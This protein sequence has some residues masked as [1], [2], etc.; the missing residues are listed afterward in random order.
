[1]A[2]KQ[3]IKAAF[4][5]VDGILTQLSANG[6]EIFYKLI[7]SNA[8]NRSKNHA[9]KSWQ[10]S[11]SKMNLFTSSS[12]VSLPLKIYFRIFT[13]MANIFGRYL[14]GWMSQNGDDGKRI[15]KNG[16]RATCEEMMK[17]FTRHALL[18]RREKD[19]KIER[20]RVGQREKK[21]IISAVES[22]AAFSQPNPN[23][24]K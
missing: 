8:W 21:I 14:A 6:T 13:L 23:S 15:A 17:R 4:T 18:K 3:K 19:G 10:V 22:T 24:W 2:N 11:R 5:F 9:V 16:D 20:E 7:S 1:M 12:S